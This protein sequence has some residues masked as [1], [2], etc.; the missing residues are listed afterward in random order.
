MSITRNNHYVSQ[1]HQR[2]FIKHG[3]SRLHY[4]DLN[5]DAIKRPDGSD[6]LLPNGKIKIHNNYNDHPTSKC[7]V[8]EDLY[9]TFFG[10]YIND[11]IERRLFGKIDDTGKKAIEAFATDDISKWHQNFS[12]LFSYVDAQK[13]R[14]PKGLDWIEKHYSNLDQN[15]LMV[16]MQSIRQKHCTIWTEGVREIVSAKN[17]NIKFILSDHPVTIYNFACSHDHEKSIYP[18][19]PSIALKASQTIFPLNMD[20]CLILTN[21]EYAKNPNINDPLEKRTNA[22]NFAN[23]LVRTDAFIKK[24]LFNEKDVSKINFIIKSR[25]K[26]YVAAS[27][28]DE[29][30]P[31]KIINTDWK[32]LGTI[33]QP[34]SDELWRFG[35][36]TYVGYTNGESSYQDAFGRT[37]PVNDF[38]NKP[39]RKGKIK[40]NEFCVCGSGKKYK[41]CCKDKDPSKK[42]SSRVLSIRERNLAFY[43]GIVNILEISN[44]RTWDDVKKNLSDDQVKKIHELYGALWTRD[45]DIFSLLPKPDNT[46]RALYTGI[47]DPRVITRFALSSTIYFDEIL[48]QNPFTN[49]N[50]IK[51][52][53]NPVQNPNQYKL[54][55]LKNVF[56]LFC[57]EPFIRSGYINFIP[58]PCCFD[59]YMQQQMFNLAE[60]RLGN[61]SIDEEEKEVFLELQKDDFNRI[62][63]MLPVN[64]QQKM[65]RKATPDITTEAAEKVIKFLNQ[66][67]LSNP[68]TLLQDDVYQNGGQLTT[69]DMS[70]NFEMSLLICQVTGSFLLTDSSFRWKEILGTQGT[71]NNSDGNWNDIENCITELRYP[72]NLNP[73]ISFNLRKLGKAGK[74]RSVMRNVYSKIH[75]LTPEN[76]ISFKDQY[77]EAYLNLKKE[78]LFDKEYGFSSKWKCIIPR[79]GIKH[80]NVQRMILSCGV[81]NS[82]QGVPM[83]IFMNF[84]K[85]KNES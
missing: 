42:T 55:T 36:E 80:N 25:A 8:K 2:G 64:Q 17:S 58:D 78:G 79:N 65:L 31:E 40:P 37:A 85:N 43:Q 68:Y 11:E 51:P 18:D 22:R 24:R 45:I 32:A 53:F 77:A 19:D 33:L 38:L 66:E 83:A 72:L 61:Y 46:L 49:P 30:F 6:V 28:K 74:L 35:G 4:L 71:I 20:H 1:W 63:S 41:K 3:E 60:S 47:V 16:E 69:L 75:N 56:L 81:E 54:Q 13:I 29:L 34:P 52:E 70:P 50:N 67:K 15:Q 12:N 5:P 57:L 23:S 73:E 39:E 10:Q 44:G 84:D 48:I 14:T 62:Q 27:K 7:F 82:L 76:I 21:Y 9:S 26:R 59:S